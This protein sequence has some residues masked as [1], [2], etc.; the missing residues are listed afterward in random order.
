MRLIGLIEN[1]FLKTSGYNN[2]QEISYIRWNVKWNV[3]WWGRII[4]IVSDAIRLIGS[5]E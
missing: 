2:E 5:D 1:I 4:N 3:T